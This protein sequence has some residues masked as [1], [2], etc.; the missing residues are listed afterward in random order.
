[1]ALEAPHN[2][3]HLVTQIGQGLSKRYDE[4]V[5]AVGR[6]ERLAPSEDNAH[7]IDLSVPLSLSI[8]NSERHRFNH[9]QRSTPYARPPCVKE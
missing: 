8:L 5:D 4:N 3:L 6:I 1:M 9:Q 2:D 7:A